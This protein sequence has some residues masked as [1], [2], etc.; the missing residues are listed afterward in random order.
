MSKPTSQLTQFSLRLFLLVV[1]GFT[2]CH[3][4]ADAAPSAHSSTRGNADDA[5]GDLYIRIADIGCVPNPSAS[6]S[7]VFRRSQSDLL[8]DAQPGLQ[9]PPATREEQT[10]TAGH[11]RRIGEVLITR[12]SVFDLTQPG[13]NNALYRWANRFRILTREDV[14]RDELLFSA[15]ETYSASIL[16]ESARLLHQRNHISDAVIQV[17]S[18]CGDEVDV[19]VV[20]QDVWSFTPEA[21]FDRSGGQDLYTIGMRD[22]NL[23]GKGT[24]WSIAIRE[25]LDR[26]SVRTLVEDEN[27]RGSRVAVSLLYEDSDDGQHAFARV[28]QPFYALDTSSAWLVSQDNLRR[29]SGQYARGIERSRIQEDIRETQLWYGRAIEDRRDHVLR[30]KAGWVYRDEAFEM[31]PGL[32]PPFPV[33][34]D[35][36]LSYLW[37]SLEG[38]S[39]KFATVTNLNQIHQTEDIYVG[40]SWRLRLGHSHPSLGATYRH[41]VADVAIGQ[42]LV[43]TASTLVQHQASGFGR[44]ETS[45]HGEDVLFRYRVHL[46]HRRNR[47]RS[48]LFAAQLDWSEGLRAHRQL[49]L[50]GLNGARGFGNR[51]QNGTRRWQITGEK[52]WFSD[53]HF[54]NL[55]RVGYATFLDA[56]RAWR[57]RLP[58]HP[59]GS[60]ANVGIG[61]RLA[62]SKSDVGKV[63]HVD[64]AFPLTH[65]NE[66]SVEDFELAATIKNSF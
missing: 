15:G 19:E 44:F 11:K 6:D 55:V 4:Y 25:N 51:F 2:R 59:E 14:V 17:V 58:G 45:G 7:S 62:S 35:Q 5:T 40:Q 32:P 49:S 10:A 13:E 8:I 47:N 64:L 16:K 9:N 57:S 28:R 66:S 65:V 29:E 3:G 63:V 21:S 27:W 43:H 53:I 36:R 61:L 60:L 20:T 39:D 24:E 34:Q 18:V 54:L 30:W 42:T 26:R 46:H 12:L 52:R 48:W 38:L 31:T 23:F 1:L 41:W 33:P 22:T 37:I 50:G 56:G